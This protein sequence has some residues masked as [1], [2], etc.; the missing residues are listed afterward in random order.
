MNLRHLY[1]RIMGHIKPFDT[2]DAV[3]TVTWQ[4][5]SIYPF[6]VPG[7]RKFLADNGCS[8]RNNFPNPLCCFEL[9]NI[10]IDR[11]GISALAEKGYHKSIMNYLC[12][13][14]AVAKT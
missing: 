3:L 12:H 7:I 6:F 13:I 5:K 1:H 2:K 14:V 11:E 10:E 8:Y 4:D 9:N